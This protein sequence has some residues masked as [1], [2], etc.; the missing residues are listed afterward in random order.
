MQRRTV[1]QWRDWLLDYVGE[2]KY[3]LIRKDSL[4]VHSVVANNAMD[5]EN[6][7]RRLMVEAKNSGIALP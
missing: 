6:Q 7:C 2:N 3:E 4:S 5:A 1:H